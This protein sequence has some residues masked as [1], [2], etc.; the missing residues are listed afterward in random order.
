MTKRFA[1]GIMMAVFPTAASL[2]VLPL[3][4]S[5]EATEAP[6]AITDST[7][8]ECLEIENNLRRLRCYDEALG[9]EQATTEP[10][11]AASQG[12]QFTERKDSFSG[13]ETSVASLESDRANDRIP[14]A[15]YPT[16]I[17]VRCDGEGGAEIFVIASGF[18]SI[19]RTPVRYKFGDAEPIRET[20]DPSTAGTTAFLPSNFRDFRA[21]LESGED[22][23]FE[24]TTH[25][26]QPYS[27]N[28][29]GAMINREHFEY[30][31]NGCR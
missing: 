16:H 13:Q 30:T 20:W 6:S 5:A 17:A 7:V 21:G 23:V 2:V 8:T 3:S 18:V 1:L 22:F 11:N 12:W 10:Q 15:S 27:A 28:F 25:R 26:G 31:Y 19:D 14:G 29:S 24:V 4:A 9:F